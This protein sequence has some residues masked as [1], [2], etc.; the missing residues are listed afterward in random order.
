[1]LRIRRD[2]C[3]EVENLDVAVRFGNEDV[4][5]RQPAMD[6]ARVVG[7]RKGRGRVSSH[8]AR[9]CSRQAS[10][11]FEQGFKAFNADAF[12]NGV[13]CAV[14]VGAEIRQVEH[15]GV[16]YFPRHACLLEKTTDFT[17][18]RRQ[19][20][21]EQLKH[22]GLVHQ[23]VPAAIKIARGPPAINSPTS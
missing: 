17:V 3:G 6:D 18:V 1:M 5:R 11:P 23:N 16:R 19:F 15:V 20:P 9:R 4:R 8:I 14:G 22:L 12:E 13:R 2:G 7:R 21:R 10:G